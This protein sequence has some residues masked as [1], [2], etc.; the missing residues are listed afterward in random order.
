MISAVFSRFSG[1]F[2]GYRGTSILSVS[3]L[4]DLSYRLGEKEVVIFWLDAKV[5]EYR[6]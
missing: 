5:L 4:A 3:M 6:V 1:G 2:S